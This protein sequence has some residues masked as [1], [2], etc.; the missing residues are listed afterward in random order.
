[1]EL[2]NYDVQ[3]MNTKEMKKV[4]GGILVWLLAAIMISCLIVVIVQPEM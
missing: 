1:M 3:E 2:K 4:D